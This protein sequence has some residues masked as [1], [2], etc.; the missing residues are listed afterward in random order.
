LAFASLLSQKYK[1][2]GVPPVAGASQL[3]ASW[4]TCGVAVGAAGV[5]GTVVTATVVVVDS[6]DVPKEFVAL[7]LIV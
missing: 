3:T 2:I 1:V 5:A 7:T 6:G 4:L